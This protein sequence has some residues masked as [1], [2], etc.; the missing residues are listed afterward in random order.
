MI[1]T[2]HS[3]RY[4]NHTEK[5]MRILFIQLSLQTTGLLLTKGSGWF[6]AG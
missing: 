2:L 3:L 6:A 1:D 5:L 4:H